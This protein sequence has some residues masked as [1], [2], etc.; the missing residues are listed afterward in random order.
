MTDNVRPEQHQEKHVNSTIE[1]L[2][3]IAAQ[4][5]ALRD[6]LTTP[7]AATWPP[8]G[9]G[10]YL[11]R[12]DDEGRDAFHDEQ[13]AERADR[14][15]TAPGQRPAPLR[16]SVLDALIE[17]EDELLALADEIASAVQRPAFTVR[18]AS[19]LDEVARSI[20]LMGARDAADPR[21]WRFNMA[22]R[23]GATAAAWLADRLDGPAGPHRALTDAEHHRVAAVASACRTRLDR[24]LGEYTDGETALGRE[25]A[26]G[27]ELTLTT[28]PDDFT[29]RCSGC[30]T[31]WTGTSLIRGL[32][33]A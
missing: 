18:S 11:S 28:G 22:T 2:R 8:A 30:G 21:R 20:A 31:T 7:A 5:P 3:H 23:T 24:A 29:I 25:C 33:A 15:A 4:W 19:P 17:I 27:A 12:L 16:V 26:C 9:L 10:T 6:Q 13:A 32:S 14:T 1:T